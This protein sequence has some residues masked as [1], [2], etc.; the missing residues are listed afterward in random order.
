MVGLAGEGVGPADE[1]VGPVSEK[2]GAAPDELCLSSM[3][4]YTGAR[5]PEWS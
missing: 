3:S 5:L 2:A 4:S 1:E